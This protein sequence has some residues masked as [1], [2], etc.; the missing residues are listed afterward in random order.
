MNRIILLKSTCLRL[1]NANRSSQSQ[2]DSSGN[3]SMHGGIIEGDVVLMLSP[4]HVDS[5][6]K[7]IHSFC[8]TDK[9][10]GVLIRDLSSC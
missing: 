1:S 8:L 6:E 5:N 3:V 2:L 4:L 9:A 10:L 7:G